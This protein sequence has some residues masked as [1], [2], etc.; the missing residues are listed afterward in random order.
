MNTLLVN[1]IPTFAT[2]I[3]ESELPRDGLIDAFI[4][5]MT[6][7]VCELAYVMSMRPHLTD[8]SPREDHIIAASISRVA[9]VLDDLTKIRD[10]VD[11]RRRQERRKKSDRE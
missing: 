8:S 9:R 4:G 6:D 11:E 10:E 7:C 1:D 5:D 3:E 2:W